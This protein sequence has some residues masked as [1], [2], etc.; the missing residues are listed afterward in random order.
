MAFDWKIVEVAGM[1]NDTHLPQE[2]NGQ[3]FVS[4]KY[5]NPHDDVPSAFDLQSRARGMACELAIEF[6]EILAQTIEK[7]RLDLFAPIEQHRG[8][9]LDRSVH[10]EIGIGDDFQARS[11]FGDRFFGAAGG[12]PGKLHLREGGNLGNSAEGE[13]ERVGVGH[14]TAAQ[15]TVMRIIEK[16]FVD[17]QSQTVVTAESVERRGFR[18]RDVR[19]GWIVGMDENHGA[20]PDGGCFVERIEVELPTV[21]VEERIRNEFNVGE[22]G[23][24]LEQRVARFGY[25]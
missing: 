23:E 19:A 13:G 3:I 24:K 18:S 1:D 22:I 11:C 10:G 20:R 14:E 8:G 12:H 7:N 21:I 15:G 17:D 6:R 9:K 4:S 25:K 16:N 5:G 2:I